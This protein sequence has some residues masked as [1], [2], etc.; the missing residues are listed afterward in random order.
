MAD[1]FGR[2]LHDRRQIFVGR[3][4]WQ[5]KLA[6]FIIHLTSALDCHGLRELTCDCVLR[7]ANVMS[8]RIVLNRSYR[9]ACHRLKMPSP[10][11]RSVNYV[12]LLQQK[13]LQVSISSRSLVLKL[14]QFDACLE[15]SRNNQPALFWKFWTSFK[16]LNI[17]PVEIMAE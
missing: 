5:T 1:K 6:N 12:W 4:Y 16:F 14:R 15:I 3:F 13:N 9:T 17:H 10:G 11:I 8:C 2:F 7:V